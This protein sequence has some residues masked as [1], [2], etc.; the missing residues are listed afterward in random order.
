MMWTASM[1]VLL[2]SEILLMERMM[3]PRW[4]EKEEREKEKERKREI[5]NLKCIVL[6]VNNLK[7]SLFIFN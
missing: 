7:E 3:S 4:R 2:V 5:S 6:S 1:C